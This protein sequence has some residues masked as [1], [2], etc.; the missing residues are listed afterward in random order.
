LN[1]SI[2][3]GLTDMDAI[4][5][6]ISEMAS[7]KLIESGFA[8]RLIMVAALSNLVFKAG[9]VAVLFGLGFGAGAAV[10]VLWP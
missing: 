3:S 10:T 7:R 8:W 1:V 5:L 2:I 4:A 9:V 6:S